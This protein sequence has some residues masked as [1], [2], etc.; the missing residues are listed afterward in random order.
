MA[1][2]TELPEFVA[3]PCARI[4]EQHLLRLVPHPL[5]TDKVVGMLAGGAKSKWRHGQCGEPG[6]GAGGAALVLACLHSPAHLPPMHTNPPRPRTHL[7]TPGGTTI[8]WVGD[9]WDWVRSAAAARRSQF[10]GGNHDG[11]I[12]WGALAKALQA[13]AAAKL[14]GSTSFSSAKVKHS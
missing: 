8:F 1:A 2:G 4:L 11:H 5:N 14:A 7:P 9:V 12:S 13:E 10:A 3:L 6:S